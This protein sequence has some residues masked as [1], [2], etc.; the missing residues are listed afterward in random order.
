VAKRN[1]D[2]VNLNLGSGDSSWYQ[3]WTN[4]DWSERTSPDIVADIN[5]LPFEDESVDRILVS[6][7]LEH[8][9]YPEDREY[10]YEWYRVL[11]VGGICTIVVPDLMGSYL[12]MQH[13]GTWGVKK[14]PIDITYLNAVAYGG[15]YLCRD[16]PVKETEHQQIFIFD[17]LVERMRPFFPD[18][19]QVVGCFIT[20]TQ[21]RWSI[22]GE[23]MAQG[24]KY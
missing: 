7:V 9:H 5:K 4:V 8:I 10:L 19:K 12:M 20:D 14:N 2:I 23:T 1:G 18:A 21:T 24:T 6:H 22:C 16:L 17:M 11:K 15:K 13:G 3:G